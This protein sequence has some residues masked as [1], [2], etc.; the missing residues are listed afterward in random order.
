MVLALKKLRYT[1]KKQEFYFLKFLQKILFF[2]QIIR[3]QIKKSLIL[4]FFR[5]INN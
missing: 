4:I 5:E 1:F 3:D 2:F